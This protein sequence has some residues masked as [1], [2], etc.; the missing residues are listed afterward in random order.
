MI[1]RKIETTTTI[2]RL[3][4]KQPAAS[5]LLKQKKVFIQQNLSL[6]HAAV[7]LHLILML[8][9]ML[10]KLS[11]ESCGLGWIFWHFRWK[12]AILLLA[13]LVFLSIFGLVGSIL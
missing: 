5:T 10:V 12:L 11:C 3:Q 9:F 7:F 2:A 4:Q 13:S 1:H 6:S 8:L